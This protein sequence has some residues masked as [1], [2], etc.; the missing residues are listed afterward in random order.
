MEQNSIYEYILSRV[1]TDLARYGYKRSGKSRF[2]YQYAVGGKV[3]CII[4]MQKSMFNSPDSYSFTF[5]LGCI[6]MY[7]L[8]GYQK[9]KLTLNV[10]K[11]ALSNPYTGAIRIGQLQRGGDYWWEL[12]ENILKM[13]TLE[14]YYNRFIQKDIECATECLKKLADEKSLVY[15]YDKN[16]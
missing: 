14:E 1:Q 7:Q 8:L 3:G 2:F 11:L 16:R 5:N 10:L 6:G 15:K 13:Y 4:E 9:E 12:N